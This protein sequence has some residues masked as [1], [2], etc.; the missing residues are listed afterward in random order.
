MQE[1]K[2]NPSACVEEFCCEWDKRKIG[3][4]SPN[5]RKATELSGLGRAFNGF[6]APFAFLAFSGIKIYAWD[7]IFRPNAKKIAKL[8]AGKIENL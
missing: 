5:G 1:A 8:A 4:Y 6:K 2:L 3:I 7:A